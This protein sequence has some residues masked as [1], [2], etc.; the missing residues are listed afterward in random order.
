MGGRQVPGLE[1]REKRAAGSACLAMF[2]RSA[3]RN[4]DNVSTISRSTFK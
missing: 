1:W 4:A 2:E 3:L